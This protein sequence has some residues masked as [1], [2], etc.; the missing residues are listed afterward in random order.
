MS[1]PQAQ[2]R[3]VMVRKKNHLLLF[4]MRTK[5]L[6]IIPT[7]KDTELSYYREHTQIYKTNTQV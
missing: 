4:T 7:Q 6:P 2:I 3:V 1:Q 5:R